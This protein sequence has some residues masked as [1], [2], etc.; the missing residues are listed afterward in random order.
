MPLFGIAFAIF[1]LARSKQ[2]LLI[3]A[4]LGLFLSSFSLLVL[5]ATMGGLQ[6]NLQQRAKEVVGHGEFILKDQS[7]TFSLKI[8]KE[9][10]DAGVDN[11]REYQ[12]ELLARRN[13]QL[14]PLIIHGVQ[15]N[16]T[17]PPYLKGIEFADSLTLGADIAY[18][19][20]AAPFDHIQLI[21]PAHIDPMLGGIPR[22]VSEPLKKIISTGVPEVDSYHGWVRSSLVH[23]LIQEVRYNKIRHYTNAPRVVAQIAQQ[24]QDRLFYRSWE[25][26]NQG[27]VKALRLEST[28]MTVLFVAMTFLVAISITSGLF[29]FYQKIQP[30]NAWTL[31]FGGQRTTTA[32]RLPMVYSSLGTSDLWPCPICSIGLL[33][34]IGLLVPCCHA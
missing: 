34:T 28:V 23:N 6:R 8:Q 29:I 30:R 11:F 9:L 20:K 15:W 4:L 26:I 27:L 18:K 17:P 25:Q 12:I 33:K 13:S 22:Q 16:N 5:Q 21:S 2:K 1:F 7:P 24:H 3:L 32:L 31:D 10:W 14:A 19:L